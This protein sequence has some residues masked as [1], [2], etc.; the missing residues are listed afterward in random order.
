[1]ISSN[2]EVTTNEMIFDPPVLITS[3]MAL[4]WNAILLRMGLG[5]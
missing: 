5:R 4:N 3:N 1:M 2:A